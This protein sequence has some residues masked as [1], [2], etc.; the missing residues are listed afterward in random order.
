MEIIA[1]CNDR[2]GKVVN[3]SDRGTCL[4][5]ATTVANELLHPLTQRLC[6]E[7]LYYHSINVV[8]KIYDWISVHGVTVG[9]MQWG[10][11]L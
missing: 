11:P 7:S 2:L 1:D 10:Q 4:A 9:L 5:I 8:G 3:Q 6:I